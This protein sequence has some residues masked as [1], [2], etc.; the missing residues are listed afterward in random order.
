MLDAIKWWMLQTQRMLCLTFS[1]R[2]LRVKTH[3]SADSNI[4]ITTQIRSEYTLK[5]LFPLFLVVWYFLPPYIRRGFK[6]Q[7]SKIHHE[8][9]SVMGKVIIHD[10]KY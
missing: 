10:H 7:Q 3:L 5:L 8:L 2:V 6:V 9:S 4:L 1:L